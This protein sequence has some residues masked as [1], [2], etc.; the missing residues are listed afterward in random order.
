[1]MFLRAL[2]RDGSLGAR[3]IVAE[4]MLALLA[5]GLDL[6]VPEHGSLGASGDLA[7]SPTAASARAS[8]GRPRAS[9]CRRPTASPRPR[10]S[11]SR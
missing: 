5:A 11:R 2:A 4:T 9:A 3:L 10:S 7:R 8:C 1:M 6:V